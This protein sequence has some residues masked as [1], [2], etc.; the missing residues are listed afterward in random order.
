MYKR[1]YKVRKYYRFDDG[2]TTT[3]FFGA[4]INLPQYK[5][6]FALQP[7]N[8]KTKWNIPR[9]YVYPFDNVYWDGM[10]KN[11]IVYDVERD[12]LLQGK[13]PE[14]DFT[15]LK[16]FI[17]ENKDVILKYWKQ[18]YDSKDLCDHLKFTN[19]DKNMIQGE[20]KRNREIIK[21]ISN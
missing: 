10:D 9:V 2:Y 4:R 13:M 6:R 14:E 7:T 21:E 12:I 20:L 15:V 18:E 8:L 3:C 16:N 11:T 17:V 5:I 1:A 19:N